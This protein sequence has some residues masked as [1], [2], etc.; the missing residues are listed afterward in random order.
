MPRDLADGE[1]TEVQ[2]SAKQPYV[3][4]NTGGVYSCTCPAWPQSTL[5]SAR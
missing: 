2:G 3:L 1:S 5:E 4:T